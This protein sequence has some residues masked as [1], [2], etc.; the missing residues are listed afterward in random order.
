MK[1]NFR[2]KFIDD[3]GP[4]LDARFV[5]LGNFIY[6]VQDFVFGIPSTNNIGSFYKR[7]YRR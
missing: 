4:F 5:F 6:F 1:V 7:F 2:R 3:F